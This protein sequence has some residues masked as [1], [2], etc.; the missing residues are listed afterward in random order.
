VQVSKVV[1]P[2]AWQKEYQA[3]ARRQEELLGKARA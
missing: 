1:E 3:F 2:S